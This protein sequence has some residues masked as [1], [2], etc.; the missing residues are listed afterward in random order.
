MILPFPGLVS[1]KR[2]TRITLR[3]ANIKEGKKKKR[4]AKG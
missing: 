2:T 3:K 4:M 1:L